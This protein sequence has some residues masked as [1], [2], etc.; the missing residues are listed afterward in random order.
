V[1][2]EPEETPLEL[3]NVTIQPKIVKPILSSKSTV[4]LGTTRVPSVDKQNPLP[5][6]PLMFMI[7]NIFFYRIVLVIFGFRSRFLFAIRNALL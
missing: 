4:P 6:S 1:E 3:T 7:G 5:N 2:R